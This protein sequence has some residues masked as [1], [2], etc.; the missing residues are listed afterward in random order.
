MGDGF[1]D[2]APK[3]MSYH[4]TELSCTG[5]MAL[6]SAL[7]S[8]FVSCFICRSRGG[9]VEDEDEDAVELPNSV[10][11]EDG[12]DEPS[13][14]R[15][16]GVEEEEDGAEDVVVVVSA[17]SSIGVSTVEREREDAASSSSAAAADASFSL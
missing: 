17:F 10:A 11:M 12:E 9:V 13:S 1:D 3:C 8:S 5:E 6:T 2:W 7:K 15:E 16:D 14:A 4:A